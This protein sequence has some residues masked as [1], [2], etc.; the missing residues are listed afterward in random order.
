MILPKII[1]GTYV[2]ATCGATAAE[3]MVVPRNSRPSTL[4]KWGLPETLALDDET[5]LVVRDACGFQSTPLNIATRA[6]T[7][8]LLAI[9]AVAPSLG[10][11]LSRSWC[12]KC[13]SY[14]CK[15][16][17]LIMP[18]Y[19]DLTEPGDGGWYDC[20]YGTCPKGHRT[21]LDD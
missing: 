3:V 2:C 17:W 19:E 9:S 4:A 20:T 7:V 6:V 16:H 5:G 1:R 15:Q 14:Y 12:P 10:A 13:R 11:A 21:M 8:A 18:V